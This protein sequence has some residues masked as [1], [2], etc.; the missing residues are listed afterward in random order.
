MSPKQ[1]ERA[2]TIAEAAAVKSVSP[3]TIRRAIKA[4]EGN[5]LR[6]KNI[7]TE[8]HPR[9]RIPASSLEDWFDGLVDV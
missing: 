1:A 7:G 2:Y 3:D 6:A 5:L 8:K 9:Y 4:T